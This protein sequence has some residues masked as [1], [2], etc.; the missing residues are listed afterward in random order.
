MGAAAPGPKG[1]PC[2]GCMPSI[3]MEP[4]CACICSDWPC[5]W[6]CACWSACAWAWACCSKERLRDRF[7]ELFKGRRPPPDIRETEEACEGVS[8]TEESVDTGEPTTRTRPGLLEDLAVLAPEATPPM[9]CRRE[10]LAEQTSTGTSSAMLAPPERAGRAER[11]P[12]LLLGLLRTTLGTTSTGTSM[13][14][15]GLPLAESGVPFC[16]ADEGIRAGPEPL[17]L[18]TL[19]PEGRLAELRTEEGSWQGA[20]WKAEL[21][22]GSGGTVRSEPR[23]ASEGSSTA[24]AGSVVGGQSSGAAE[25]IRVSRG[26]F[27]LKY[28]SPSALMRLVFGP[29]PPHSAMSP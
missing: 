3:C 11:S 28:S 15:P 21:T 14:V 8:S 19:G 25:L 22:H 20:D 12:R 23:P 6:A 17:V 18:A 2:G 7:I 9:V 16:F 10:G 26:K 13:G 5:T 27:V 24:A 1:W 4:P 29:A